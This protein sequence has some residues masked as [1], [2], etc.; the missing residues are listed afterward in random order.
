MNSPRRSMPA[1]MIYDVDPTKNCIFPSTAWR[2]EMER[3]W[4]TM[5]VNLIY[6]YS[7]YDF[8]QLILKSLECVNNI[9]FEQEYVFN[10]IPYSIVTR[11]IDEADDMEG[12]S[13]DNADIRSPIIIQKVL[14]KKGKDTWWDTHRLLRYAGPLNDF[15]NCKDIRMRDLFESDSVTPDEWHVYTLL[16]MNKPIVIKK[17]DLL[18]RE[19]LVQ[20]KI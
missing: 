20:D 13:V 19:S 8:R 16:N 1:K 5:D 18:S 2:N 10:N 9:R 12:P 4:E 6:T 11:N 15:H 3:Q 14:A 7:C 17:D